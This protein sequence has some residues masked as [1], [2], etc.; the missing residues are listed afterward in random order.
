M[1]KTNILMVCLGNICRSPLA[2]GILRNKLDSEQFIIDSA[3]TGDWHVGNAPDN[4]SIKVARDNG[5]DISQLKGRQIAKS[6]FK[7]FDHIYV[8]D[9]NNLEDVLALASTDEERRKVIMILDTVFPGEKVDVPDPYNGMQEDFERVYE[10]LDQ[11]CEEI[12]GQLQ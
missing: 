1:S 10:M 3:G 8:M 2:E 5:I 11:A 6:D 9:Q 4:R 12:V 7:K